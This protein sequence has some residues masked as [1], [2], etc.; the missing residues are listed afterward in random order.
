MRLQIDTDLFMITN[1]NAYHSVIKDWYLEGDSV[2]KNKFDSFLY[3]NTNLNGFGGRTF[4]SRMATNADMM[5]VI[6]KYNRDF[7]GGV[8]PP[9][10]SKNPFYTL[11]S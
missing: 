6:K 9:F 8:I 7:D 1:H 3:S 2:Q 5:L 10:K 11:K 4:N